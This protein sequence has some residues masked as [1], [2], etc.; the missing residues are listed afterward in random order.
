MWKWIVGALLLLVVALFAT[1]YVGYKKLTAG[2]DAARVTIG[3]SADRVWAT[4][5]DPDS[6]S[7]W[8]SDGSTVTGTRHGTVVV[9]DT[10]HIATASR[11]KSQNFTW[12]VSE[13]TAGRLIALEMRNDSSGKVFATRRDS[14][15]SE[16]DSTTVVST[17]GSPMIDSIRTQ[18][19]DTGGKIGG[20]V[21]DFSSKMLVS[22]FRLASEQDLKRLK[23]HLEGKPMP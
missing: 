6:M 22:A 21:L 18:R 20:A 9:G 1:C 3:A 14:V 4:L 2:G 5:A 12:T 11:S 16:G 19:G 10:L 15:V 8:M 17:I 23:A 7:T 13:V